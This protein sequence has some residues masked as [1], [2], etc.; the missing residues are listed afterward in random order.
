WIGIP[1][2]FRIKHFIEKEFDVLINTAMKSNRPLEYVSTYSKAKLR[3][4]KYDQQ[5]TFAYDFMMQT[6]NE[7]VFSYLAQV[8]HYLRMV[9][10]EP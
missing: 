8:E 1:K 9:K 5:K 4:G 7:D 3:I 6:E 10:T 2:M